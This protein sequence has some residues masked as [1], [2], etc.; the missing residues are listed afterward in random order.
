[1]YGCNYFSSPSVPTNNALIPL[2]SDRVTSP[3]TRQ[4]PPSGKSLHKTTATPVPTARPLCSEQ[5]V[6]T[7][8]G[9]ERAKG[10]L[11]PSAPVGNFNHHLLRTPHTDTGA[12]TGHE[13]I[14][15]PTPPATGSVNADQLT[16]NVH[17]PHSVPGSQYAGSRLCV[18][19][20]EEFHSMLNTA[21][22]KIQRWYRAHR[23]QEHVNVVRLLSQKRAELSQSIAES[24]ARLVRLSQEKEKAGQEKQRR[25]EE[26]A[27]EAR[28]A[29][30]A[31]LQRKREEKRLLAQQVAEEEFVSGTLLYARTYVRT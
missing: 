23:H 18:V 27:R 31:A 22:T 20:S 11:V 7:A 25:K 14:P 4:G 3:P 9:R 15:A 26:R 8:S 28:Q 24:Q 10:D 12:G 30:I 6:D 13:F 17:D 19:D 29:A 2:Q 16:G 1:M 21:A 5:K